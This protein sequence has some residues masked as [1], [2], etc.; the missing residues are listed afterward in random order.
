MIKNLFNQINS[1]KDKKK[2]I[3]IRAGRTTGRLPHA[4]LALAANLDDEVLILDGATPNLVLHHRK[5]FENAICVGIS[6]ITGPFIKYSLEVAQLIR[7]IN[8]ELPLIWGG[9]HPSLKP[10]QTLENEFVDKVIVGQGEKSFKDLVNKNIKGGKGINEIEGIIHNQFVDK[11]KFP[12]YNFDLIKDIENYISPYVS[13][14]TISLYTS[15]GCP[16]GCSFCAINSVYGRKNSG[17]P[18]AGIIDL[19]N[20]SIK[21]Y[22]IDGVHFD[23]D[24]FFIGKKR[25]LKFANQLLKRNIKINWSSDARID[26]L[27]SLD[28]EEWEIIDRS[29][30]KR[31]LV[32][33]E[34]GVQSTL[35]KLNKKIT[36]EMILEF[37][38][39]CSKYKIIP[40]FSMMVGVPGETR[41][42]IEG[43]FSLINT[44]R[45]KVPTCELL[46]FLYTPYPGTPL[47]EIS[48]ELGFKEPQCLEDWGQFYL[49]VSTV[50]WVDEEL[51]Q[52]VNKLNKRLPL[53]RDISL[54]NGNNFKFNHR[55]YINKSKHLISKFR[56]T[57]NKTQSLLRYCKRLNV[58]T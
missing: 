26:I 38:N 19:I 58:K 48:V 17:W 23:D 11:G 51:T 13:P 46:L 49:N 34:S 53:H 31:F 8:P 25:A 29:G 5:D 22:G 54:K 6:T 57:E 47:Y 12:I 2:V 41:E 32:G 33:A 56:Q 14:R 30:C 44:L 52:R 40:C 20:H 7:T 50:P 42:D 15:Q 1:R 27:C 55:I 39:L 4:L 3:L 35:D 36:P 9:W 18:V 45:E 16:F 28:K 37:G 21:N 24:N 10:K 43:T